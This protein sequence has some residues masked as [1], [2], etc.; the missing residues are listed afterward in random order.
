MRFGYYTSLS[1]CSKLRL[2]MW[3]RD[4]TDYTMMHKRHRGH[5]RKGILLL[6][7]RT[8]AF[9]KKGGNLSYNLFLIHLHNKDRSLLRKFKFKPEDG[10]HPHNRTGVSVL[11]NQD[12]VRFEISMDDARLMR[13]MKCICDLLNNAK[14]PR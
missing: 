12:V 11:V 10:S 6:L 5:T 2:A 8:A 7:N 4:N 9:R 13:S 14:R 3:E 1:A